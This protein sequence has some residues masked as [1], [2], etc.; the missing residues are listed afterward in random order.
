MS[1]VAWSGLDPEPLG[2]IVVDGETLLERY[3]ERR[4]VFGLSAETAFGAL[5]LR[6]E[7][8]W[9]PDRYFNTRMAGELAAVPLDQHRGVLALDIDGPLGVFINAQYLVDAVR[10][11]PA[12]LVRPA[13]D[14]IATLFLRRSFNY[15]RLDAELRWYHS[16]ED[17]DDLVALAFEYDVTQDTR[18]TLSIESFD[19]APTGLFGQFEDR[20]RV[21]FGIEHT[22]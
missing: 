20:D 6:A 9:Q 4:D 8:G 1:A 5:V 15:D 3:Y 2:R 11:A 22:F 16:V 17:A 10:D 12:G 14:R 18:L 19:G 21:T 7:Y 13:T